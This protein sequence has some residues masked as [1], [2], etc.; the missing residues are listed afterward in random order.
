MDNKKLNELAQEAVELIKEFGEISKLICGGDNLIESVHIGDDN[1]II[2]KELYKDENDEYDLFD[3][4]SILEASITYGGLDEDFDF[5]ISECMDNFN[6]MEKDEFINRIGS[7]YYGQ[8]RCE[9]I[10]E[11]LVEIEKEV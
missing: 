6:K 4:S 2:V 11:R 9:K 5:Q 8:L 10:Y 7:L 3:I 1:S